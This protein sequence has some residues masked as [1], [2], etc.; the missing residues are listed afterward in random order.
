MLS[1]P[2]AN[3]LTVT[4]PFFAISYEI[5]FATISPYCVFSLQPTIASEK[6]FNIYLFPFINSVIGLS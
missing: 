4:M 2:F 6:L 5:F 1:I 3:P